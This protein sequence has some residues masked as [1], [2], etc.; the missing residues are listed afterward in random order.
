M[1]VVEGQ[2]AFSRVGII[3]FVQTIAN[4]ILRVRSFYRIGKG[5]GVDEGELRTIQLL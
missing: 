2:E 4:R 5:E 3:E 1:M